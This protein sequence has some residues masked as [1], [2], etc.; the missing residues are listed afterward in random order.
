MNYSC[1]G[2]ILL[3]SW[4]AQEVLKVCP[5]FSAMIRACNLHPTSDMSPIISN[6]LCRAG[7]L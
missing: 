3:R 2:Y 6:N 1:L 7:S 5:G 4:R